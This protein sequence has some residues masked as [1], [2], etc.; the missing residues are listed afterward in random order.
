VKNYVDRVAMWHPHASTLQ[1][2]ASF[3][4]NN[5]VLHVNLAQALILNL[6]STQENFSLE[7]NPIASTIGNNGLIL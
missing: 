3:I 4:P 5:P 6:F 1:M 7:I 2:T